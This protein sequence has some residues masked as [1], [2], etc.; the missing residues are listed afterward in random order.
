[1]FFF[2]INKIFQVFLYEVCFDS[3]YIIKYLMI[4]TEGIRIVDCRSASPRETST[5][6]GPQNILF[7]SVP[8]N[9]IHLFT[10][11]EGNSEFRGPESLYS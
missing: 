2:K 11:T 7:P 6:S 10:G 3:W 1:M 9:I 8:I 4:E 5:V